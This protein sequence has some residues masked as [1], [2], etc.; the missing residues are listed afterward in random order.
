MGSIPSLCINICSCENGVLKSIFA[1]KSSNK[2]LSNSSA[3]IRIHYELQRNLEHRKTLT[4]TSPA[5]ELGNNLERP[6]RSKENIY[7]LYRFDKTELGSGHFGIVKK[8]RLKNSDGNQVFAIKTISRSKKIEKSEI[9]L[10]LKE[11]EY[12]KIMDHPNIVKFHEVY[13]NK[14]NFHLVLEHLSGGEL[15]DKIILEKGFLESVVKNYIWQIL[16][17]VNY[18]HNQK[19]AHRDLKPENFLFKSP[20]S[21]QIKL[22]DFGLS[23][24]YATRKMKT[25]VG[26]P[27]Y[28][29]PEVL[30]QEYD[31]RCDM[32]S[33]GVIMYL[34]MCGD[35]PFQGRSNMEVFNK[36]LEGKYDITKIRNQSPSGAS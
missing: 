22:I 30:E 28:L 4:S 21:T 1:K 25:I 11:L 18:L 35:L 12:L 36:I 16:Y 14:D 20:K 29:A 33:I 13:E 32:W 34:M 23:T 9:D 26:S 27:Y 19:I 7:N 17:A 3:H 5:P 10:F 8:A 24:N 15:L 6:T 31:E 2:D